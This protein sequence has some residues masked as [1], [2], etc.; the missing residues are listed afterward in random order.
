[1][2]LASFI[3]TCIGISDQN[4]RLSLLSIRSCSCGRV[5]GDASL[6]RG[7]PCVFDYFLERLFSLCISFLELFLDEG[8]LLDHSLLFLVYGL[9][10]LLMVAL[11]L[12][13]SVLDELMVLLVV[14]SD[15]FKLFLGFIHLELF[16]LLTTFNG[17]VD[18]VLD[19]LCFL[20]FLIKS[21]SSKI[22]SILLLGLDL[23]SLLLD[24]SGSFLLDNR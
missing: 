24:Q 11:G 18:L 20:D 5:L 14:E 9:L 7:Q 15:L 4:I 19:F 22:L 8:E 17:L 16:D 3:D 12:L 13:C 6:L 1:M 2:K 21:L 10:D 23:V